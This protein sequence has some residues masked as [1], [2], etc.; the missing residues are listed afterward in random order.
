MVPMWQRCAD[1]WFV[2]TGRR[3]SADA[4][5]QICKLRPLGT[6]QRFKPVQ[7]AADYKSPIQ[8]E[9]LRYGTGVSL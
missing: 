8:I 7:H 6:G 2:E 3:V 1:G 4:V 5:S 9:N